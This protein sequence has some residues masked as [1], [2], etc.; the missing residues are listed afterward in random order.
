MS[1]VT[2]Y[3]VFADRA[4]ADRIGQIAVEGR[5]AACVNILGSVQS[6]YRWEGEIRTG[7]EVAAIFKTTKGQANAL[8][9]RITEL[10]SYEVPCVVSYPIDQVRADY[11]AWVEESVG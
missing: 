11:Q 1:V 7:E 9:S 6:I 5:L 8:I 4:E 10:H 2:V 3:A